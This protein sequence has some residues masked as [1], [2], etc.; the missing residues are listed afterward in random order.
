MTDLEKNSV[1][2]EKEAAPAVGAVNA[3]GELP[4]PYSVSEAGTSAAGAP[5]L[6]PEYGAPGEKT[7]LYPRHGEAVV[8]SEFP[9]TH[10]LYIHTDKVTKSSLIVE[11]DFGQA[12]HG[13]VVVRVEF[14]G[15]CS[16]LRGKCDVTMELNDR[17]EYE[18]YAFGKR[19]G[20]SSP[21]VECRIVVQMP[22]EATVAHPGIRAAVHKDH[23]GMGGLPNVTFGYIHIETSHANVSLSHVVGDVISVKTEHGTID[24]NAVISQGEIALE[25]SHGQ[26]SANDIRCHKLVAATC[27]KNIT[28]D[29]CSCR[30]IT[31][32]TAN[33][34]I[35]SSK[36][37]AESMEIRTT[38]KTIDVDNVD[39]GS[40]WLATTNAS[41]IGTWTIEKL[42]DISTTNSR[43][44]GNIALK[45]PSSPVSINL[46]TT[47]SA[48]DVKLLRSTFSGRFDVRTTNA[49]AIVAVDDDDSAGAPPLRYVVDTRPYKRGTL[50]GIGNLRHELVAKTTNSA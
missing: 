40:L 38:N 39:V 18:I 23:V 5:Q 20:W 42:L 8:T 9:P 37:V 10:P 7:M 36:V 28:L 22:A 14:S 1:R 21:S 17:G 47:N 43:I 6:P 46:S 31:A 11:S 29:S 33:A 50:G 26:I 25:T 45:D 27:Y 2:A 41:I 12:S 19:S 3:G 4:P 15:G 34:K 13:M 49:M 32:E 48:I 24:V 44:V 16:D 35:N 30:F